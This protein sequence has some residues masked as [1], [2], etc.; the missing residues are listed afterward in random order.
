MTGLCLEF[1]FPNFPPLCVG[2]FTFLL[3]LH[4][5]L[6][7]TILFMFPSAKTPWKRVCMCNGCTYMLNRGSDGPR[8]QILLDKIGIFHL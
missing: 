3:F 8:K 1:L 5:V 2:C 4:F 6:Y 7:N